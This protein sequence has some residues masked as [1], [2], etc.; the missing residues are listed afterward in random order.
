MLSPQN[1][2][3][4]ALQRASQSTTVFS[5][6]ASAGGSAGRNCTT[7][8]APMTSSF[9]STDGASRLDSFLLRAI[10]MTNLWNEIARTILGYHGWVNTRRYLQMIRRNLWTAR[11]QISPRRPNRIQRVQPGKA[12]VPDMKVQ[13][14]RARVVIGKRSA[15]AERGFRSSSG[16]AGRQYSA[17]PE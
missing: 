3:N 2:R 17:W 4:R 6:L 9:P 13:A 10:G 5:V 7:N 11:K 14:Q 16:K 12:G 15:P 1:Q 8:A